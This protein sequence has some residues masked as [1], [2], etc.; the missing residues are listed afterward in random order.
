MAESTRRIPV[1][2]HP[3]IY[4]KGNRYVVRYRHHGTLHSKSFRTLSEAKRFKA[5]VD[6]GDTQP[7]SKESFRSYATRWLESYT[8]RTA[9][10][11]GQS[12]RG[13]YRDAVER[14]ALPYFKATPLERIDPPMLRQYIGHLAKRGLAPA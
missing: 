7:T 14:F 10:G 11:V 4:T 1:Q 3:G 8:G 9:R 6:S 13:S 5:K 12:T 2:G